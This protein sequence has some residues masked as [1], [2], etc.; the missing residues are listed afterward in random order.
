LP[1][2]GFWLKNWLDSGQ[3]HQAEKEVA[4]MMCN[5]SSLKS[6]ELA[7]I[8]ELEKELGTPLLAFSCRELKPADVS[9]E[10]LDKIKALETQLGM[11]LVAVTA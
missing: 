1:P 8:N 5:L 2:A 4:A 11:S 6:E 9:K 3:Q 10:Q 7:K